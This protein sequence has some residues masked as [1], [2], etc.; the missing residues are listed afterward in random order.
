M[1]WSWKSWS[2][3]AQSIIKIE[4]LRHIIFEE[5]VWLEKNLE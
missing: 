5:E 2:V 1:P 3:C 4:Y